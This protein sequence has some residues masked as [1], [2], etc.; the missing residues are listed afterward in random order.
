MKTFLLKEMNILIKMKKEIWMKRIKEILKLMK[1]GIKIKKFYQKKFNKIKWMNSFLI[2]KI[3][4]S[5]KLEE[6]ISKPME[7][8]I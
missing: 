2:M 3:R 4:R 1:K 5:K 7:E 6:Q 8:R